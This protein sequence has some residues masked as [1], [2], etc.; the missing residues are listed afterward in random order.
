MKK[1]ILAGLAMMAVS[2]G[3]M[4]DVKQLNFCTGAEGGFYDSFG[5][6]LGGDIKKQSKGRATVDYLTTEGSVS[7]ASMLKS[8]ECNIALLQADA[9]ISRPM[10]SDI[11]LSDAHS[12]AIF[13]LHG[14]TGVKDFDDMSDD[15][16]KN[17]GVAIVSGSGAEVTLRNFGNVDKKFK[18]LNII[19]FDDWFSAAKATAEGKIRRAGNDIIIAGMIYVGRMGNI[20][21][22]IT[23]D[24]KDDLTIGEI[25]VSS[26]S[27]VKDGNNN[28][29]YTKCKVEKT[30]GIKTDTWGDP[31]TYCVR[32]QVVYNNE[33]FTDMPAK[34]ARELRKSMDKAIVQNIRQ[35]QAAK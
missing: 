4:A 5:H 19:T 32:A 22:E 35:Q 18:N 1:M 16:N 28:P 33:I 6:Q 29:L 30:N 15:E 9:V 10:P 3:A 2:F 23:G 20:S 13:W 26:F 12:E 34:D 7:S 21:S 14:K 25:D 8:G 17:Y 11:A 31:V 27:D 24:F